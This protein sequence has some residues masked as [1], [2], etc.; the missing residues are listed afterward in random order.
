MTEIGEIPEEWNLKRIRDCAK[1]KYGKSNPKTKG[2]IPL[3]GSSGVFGSVSEPL[4]YT[5]TIVIGRKGTAGAVWDIR[6]PSWPSD[7]TFYLEY[8][9]EISQKFLFEFMSLNKLTGENAKTTLPSVKREEIEEFIFPF[10][11]LSE[12]QK[13]AEILSTA[14]ETIQKVNEEITFTEKLKKGLMQTLLTK[15]TGHTK[16]K[17][18][19]IGEIPENWGISELRKIF[20]IIT[21]TTPSTKIKKYWTGGTLEWLTPKDLSQMNDNLIISTSER[22]VTSEALNESNLNLLPEGSILI[23]TRAPVGYVGINRTPITFNQGCKG[24][25]PLL[26]EGYSSFFYAYYLKYKREFLNSVSSGSTFK[27]LSKE[28]L[29]RLVVPIPP[30]LEQ[31]KIAEILSTVNQKL[32]LLRNKRT[33]LKEL[34]KGLMGDLLTGKVRVKVETS[35]GEN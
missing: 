17:M 29:E 13:I 15:G 31:Q 12:Q 27:E 14:D 28:R 10:P 30:R 5:S 33:H 21:G 26:S 8:K 22:K 34:K 25:V 3:I 11:P 16:F 35:N 2:M 6:T 19:E 1:V 9:T 4:T 24:L 32:E 7:T 18:T 20:K 23:S